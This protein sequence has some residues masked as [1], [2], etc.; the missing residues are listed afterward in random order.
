MWSTGTICKLNNYGINGKILRWFHNF[1]NN[2]K[3]L[4]C[5]GNA[6]ADLHNLENSYPQGSF[7]SPILFNIIINTPDETLQ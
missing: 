2:R 5:E 6:L 4:V 7:L 1:L 3:I